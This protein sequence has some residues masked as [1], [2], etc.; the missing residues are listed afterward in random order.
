MFPFRITCN[1]QLIRLGGIWLDRH[2]QMVKGVLDV[3]LHLSWGSFHPV[4]TPQRFLQYVL[5]L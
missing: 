5:S 3:Q 2:R 1:I 4:F